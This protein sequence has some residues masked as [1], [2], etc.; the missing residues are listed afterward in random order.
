LASGD[1]VFAA[2]FMLVS[3]STTEKHNERRGNA[4]Q[5][6]VGILEGA[7]FSLSCLNAVKTSNEYY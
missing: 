2:Q 6:S 7:L 1:D 3:T 4:F 5:A